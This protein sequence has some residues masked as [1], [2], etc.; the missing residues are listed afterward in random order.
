MV[1][2]FRGSVHCF[3]TINGKV[4]RKHL[5]SQFCPRVNRLKGK[6]KTAK[7]LVPKLRISAAAFYTWHGEHV[8]V[9]TSQLL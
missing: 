5:A 7:P 3:E 6:D 8:R 4:C 1:F 9:V 2:N